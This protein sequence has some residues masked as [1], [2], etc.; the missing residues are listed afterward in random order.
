MRQAPR[1]GPQQAQRAGP[2]RPRAWAEQLQRFLWQAEPHGVLLP[3]APQR[4]A[5]ALPRLGQVRCHGRYGL[6]AQAQRRLWRPA[7]ACARWRW[8]CWQVQGRAGRELQSQKALQ[9]P[10]ASAPRRP[11]RGW[12]QALAL[13][14]AQRGAAPPPEPAT[15]CNTRSLPSA[16][17]A[18]LLD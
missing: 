13:P 12:P 7:P 8:W 11:V 16:M 15:S 10:R 2:L 17:L 3:Q 18:S 14:Q 9:H 6:Q 1:Q 4:P 5:Q